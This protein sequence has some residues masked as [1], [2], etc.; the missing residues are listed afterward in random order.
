MLH[1][2][3]RALVIHAFTNN[4]NITMTHLLKMVMLNLHKLGIGKYHNLIHY[5][6][7][8]GLHVRSLLELM[9]T[10]KLLRTSCDVTIELTTAKLNEKKPIITNL[11]YNSKK[12]YISVQ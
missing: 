3:G 12:A 1:A 6:S 8:M 7:I 11:C 9:A 5:S 4:N 10:L 2:K